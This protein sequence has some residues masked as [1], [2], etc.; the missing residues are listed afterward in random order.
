MNKNFYNLMS[1]AVIGIMALPVGIAVFVFGFYLGDNPC[2]LCWQERMGMIVIGLLGLATLRYG[3]KKF[4]LGSILVTACVGIYMTFRHVGLHAGKDIGQGFSLTIF[5]THTYTWAM[6]TYWIVLIAV[7]LMI[8]L[9]GSS[10][11]EKVQK[12]SGLKK[13]AAIVFL[14]VTAANLVQAF[15]S[16]GPPPYIAHGDPVRLSFNPAQWE[17]STAKW[18]IGKE[19]SLRG[20]YDVDRPD[21]V[22]G[23]ITQE[24]KNQSAPISASAVLTTL[25]QKDLGQ[26]FDSVVMGIDYDNTTNEFSIVSKDWTI[27]LMDSN[28]EKIKKSVTIDPYYGV[29]LEKAVDVTSLGNGK[30]NAISFNKSFVVVEDNGTADI[31]KNYRF[32]LDGYDT[33]D[34]ITRGRF[35]TVR[36]K[37]MYILGLDYDK[38]ANSYFT[39]TV[40]NNKTKK[41]ILS[42][43]DAND[44]TLSQ[45]DIVKVDSSLKVKEGRDLGEFYI[46]AMDVVE[47]KIYALSRQYNSILV[48]SKETNKVIDIY[49]FDE[50]IKDPRGLTVKDGKF[51]ILTSS[52]KLFILD[53]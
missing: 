31:N 18:P 14:V 51:Y 32:F 41:L 16:S 4:Y 8:L 43:F 5:E 12:I 7:S 29:N 21:L 22:D 48:I 52:Q 39:L 25:S 2:I 35:T 33:F 36:A 37:L 19:F 13:S 9:F 6:L 24:S 23:M 50:N 46:T 1:L 26:D 40:P 42:R 17:W 30:Y 3:A 38:E 28:L 53:K 49:A 44:R 11:N 34:H 20:A 10:E 27:Y 45:E 15:I 47:D